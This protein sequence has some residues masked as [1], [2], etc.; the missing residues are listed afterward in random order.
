MKALLETTLAALVT[1]LGRWA[2]HKFRRNSMRI[3]AVPQCF[4][5]VCDACEGEP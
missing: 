1:M 4:W 2:P 5:V 3:R